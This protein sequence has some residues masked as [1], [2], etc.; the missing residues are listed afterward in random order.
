VDAWLR[1]WA[2]SRSTEEAVA[3]LQ[4]A[5]VPAAPVR[6][7]AEAARDPHVR[8]RG[9]LQDALQEDGRPA[10]V[11]GPAAKFSRTP[12]RVRWGAPALGRD[13]DPL[14]DELGVSPEDR[15]RLRAAGVL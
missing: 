11:T 6:T 12:T 14:L 8:A 3:A 5:G 7:Y 9:M 13:N 10:P 1:E 15:A 2:A 4:A